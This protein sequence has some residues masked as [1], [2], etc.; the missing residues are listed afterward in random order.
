MREPSGPLQETYYER[1]SEE[2]DPTDMDRLRGAGLEVEYRTSRGTMKT[3]NGTQFHEAIFS[4]SE[5]GPLDGEVEESN[6]IE[7]Y[8]NTNSYL[9]EKEPL[10]LWK[11]TG[12]SSWNL[13]SDDVISV[14][15]LEYPDPSPVAGD[16]DEDFDCTVWYVTNRGNVNSFEME[17]SHIEGNRANINIT[18]ERKSDGRRIEV[19]NKYRR[20]VETFNRKIGRTARIEFPL[21]EEFKVTVKNKMGTDPE[22]IQEKIS[23]FFRRQDD[24]GV[25]VERVE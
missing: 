6:C 4:G 16:I 1:T 21:G 3:R 24:I 7:F 8:G 11:S 5:Q 18:G 23:E 22:K 9:L 10:R 17:V 14:H 13:I 12:F 2:V 19:S 20:R 25:E 15:K